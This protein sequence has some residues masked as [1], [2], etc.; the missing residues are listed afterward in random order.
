MAGLF[1]ALELSDLYFLQFFGGFLV[2]EPPGRQFRVVSDLLGR[3]ISQVIKILYF[4]TFPALRRFV[5][6]IFVKCETLRLHGSFYR[7]RTL[8]LVLD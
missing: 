8:L 2:F 3:P 6:V 4:V 7:R 5:G 1:T